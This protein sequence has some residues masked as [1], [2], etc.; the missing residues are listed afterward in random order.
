MYSNSI[1]IYIHLR[2]RRRG[3]RLRDDN[4]GAR[5]HLTATTA[6]DG[7]HQINYPIISYLAVN[8][9]SRYKYGTRRV[10]V[11]CR[12]THKRRPNSERVRPAKLE[13][14]RVVSR[15]LFCSSDI[16]IVILFFRRIPFVVFY[17]YRKI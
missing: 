1:Y 5:V 2:T 13:R 14:V 3:R 7:P 11:S 12:K 8:V 6:A 9:S 15:N 10:D 16:I 4:T 17:V